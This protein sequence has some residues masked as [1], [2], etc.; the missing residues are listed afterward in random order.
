MKVEAKWSGRYPNL[1]RGEWTLLIDGKN[2]SDK[3][4]KDLRNEPMNTK[5][6]YSSWRFGIDWEVKCDNYQDG[7]KCE[8]WIKENKEWLDRITTDKCEQEDIYYAFQLNDWRYG[9]CGGCILQ[10]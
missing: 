2:V 7:L 4:P 8:D 5:D 3:I 10:Y 1:C 9:S 6:I